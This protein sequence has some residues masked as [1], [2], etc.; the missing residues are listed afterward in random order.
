M[1]G[2]YQLLALGAALCSIGGSAFAGNG[3]NLQGVGAVNT[4]L[5]G[6]GTGASEDTLTAV[7]LNGAALAHKDGVHVDFSIL[8][9]TA[10][11]SL[12]STFPGAGSGT[13][14]GTTS[15][16]PIPA[17]AVSLGIPGMPVTSYFGVLGLAGF[18]TDYPQDNQN[19]ALAPP[20]DGFGHVYSRFQELKMPFGAAVEV[21][22]GLS[23][24]AALAVNWATLGFQP[25]VEAPGYPNTA[26][27]TGAWGVGFDVGVFYQMNDALSFGIG[28]AS[29]GWFEDFK[30]NTVGTG[31]SPA[32]PQ[33]QAQS[34][35]LD[36]NTPQR[37]TFGL[38]VRPMKG[39]LIAA[40]GRW[41]NF[42][43]T[44][45][46][47]ECGFDTK[48]LTANGLCWKNTWAA[49]LGVQYEVQES[50]ALRLG[51]NYGEVPIRSEHAASSV[52]VPATVS[53]HISA[54][55]GFEPLPGLEASFAY[56]HGFKGTVNGPFVDPKTGQGIPGSDITLDNA[57]NGWLLEMSFHFS[58]AEN[59]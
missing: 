26:D 49:A 29:T 57:L 39:L 7:F 8:I 53:Q 19:P 1:M 16:V 18:A 2:R 24:S 35:A 38:G 33:G 43:N 46:F 37:L 28:Y 32:H 27:Q 21:A 30:W 5:G 12:S 47:G 9:G 31:L 45:G 17:L 3:H 42:A 14:E 40:D 34:V 11:Y 55:L 20:P 59:P 4:A 51:Y 13:T 25:N 58:H 36:I 44:A 6:A 41:F 50:V 22:P 54:G 48:T 15:V 56:Y 52:A 10:S 23:F